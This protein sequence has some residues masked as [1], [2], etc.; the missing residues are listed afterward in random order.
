MSFRYLHETSE[1]AEGVAVVDALQAALA[2]EH[3]A[4]W[5]Y[6]LVAAYDADAAS[7]VSDMVDQHQRSRD[8]A[9]N[10]VA[11]QGAAPVSPHAAYTSAEPVDDAAS[12]HRLAITIESDCSAAWRVVIGCTDDPTL[13]GS[14]LA[15]LTESAMRLVSWRRMSDAAQLTEAFPGDPQL[16]DGV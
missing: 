9:A 11:N 10:L 8:T 15:A 2:A 4:L 1:Q 14:A 5:A 7:R 3:A 16:P 13:R 6:G 12:A